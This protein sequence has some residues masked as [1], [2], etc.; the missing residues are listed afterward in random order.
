[1]WVVL[2]LFYL[3]EIRARRLIP[4]RL[5]TVTTGPE[6]IKATAT[7]TAQSVAAAIIPAVPVTPVPAVIPAA[8]VA[9]PAAVPHAVEVIEGEAKTTRVEGAFFPSERPVIDQGG[10]WKM[11]ESLIFP[12]SARVCARI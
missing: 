12:A 8:E 9:H 3:A 11:P 7:I 5:P 2:R 4:A 1:M 10:P 6:I